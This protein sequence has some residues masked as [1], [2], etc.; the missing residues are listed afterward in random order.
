MNDFK[1]EKL[2]VS[3]NEIVANPNNPNKQSH[4][5]FQKQVESIKTFGLLGAI[6]VRKWGEYYEILGGEHRWR[7]CKEL[8]Y[9]KIPVESVGNMSDSDANTLLIV[10]NMQGEKDLEQI[11]KI[12]EELNSGQQ[13]LLPYSNDELNNLKKLFKFDFSQYSE[14]HPLKEKQTNH[15]S[16]SVT[17]ETKI[18]WDKCMEVGRQAKEKPEKT[19]LIMIDNYLAVSL[20][21]SVNETTVEF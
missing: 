6:T 15:I 1:T 18:L 9:T 8:G 14:Q 16:M 7:A 5:M 3:I 21:R 13:Q 2:I 10:L 11:A 19:L 12:V 17:E 4:E 20:G